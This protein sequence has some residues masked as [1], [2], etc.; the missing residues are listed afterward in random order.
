[1]GL[2][3]M[4]NT[5]GFSGA[6]LTEIC[7]WAAT[8]AFQQL[9]EADICRAHEKRKSG[10]GDMED[11]EEADPVPEITREHFE[12]AVKFTRRSVSDQDIRRYETF[13]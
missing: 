8:L 9:I 2:G 12:R 13:A 11:V 7:Q 10:E 1:M 5:H 4:R 6:G 3:L